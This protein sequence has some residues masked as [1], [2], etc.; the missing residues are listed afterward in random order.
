MHWSGGGFGYFPTYSLGSAYAA[1]IYDAMSY[2]IDIDEEI[3]SGELGKIALWLRDNLHK[4]GSSKFPKELIKL[5]T[6][7]SFNPDFYV[8]YLVEKYTKLYNLA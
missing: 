2:D 4:Y 7:A 1:Q 6:G 8:D 5:A 3:R